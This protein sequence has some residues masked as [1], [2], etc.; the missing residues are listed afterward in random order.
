MK[1]CSQSRA[2]FGRPFAL[3]KCTKKCE[4]WNNLH[5]EHDPESA[6]FTGFSNSQN[7]F[8]MNAFLQVVFHIRPLRTLVFDWRTSYPLLVRLQGVF[9]NMLRGR[10]VSPV[11]MAQRCDFGIHRHQDSAEF[12]MA[13]LSI[14]YSAA[15]RLPD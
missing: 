2:L 7:N 6:D 11:N 10:M 8:D 9:K 15:S 1:L 14:R 4:K 3:W 5:S 12:G 13:L